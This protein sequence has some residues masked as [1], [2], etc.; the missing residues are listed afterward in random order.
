MNTRVARRSVRQVGGLCPGCAALYWRCQRAARARARIGDDE[1]RMMG[2]RSSHRGPKRVRGSKIHPEDRSGQGQVAGVL[3]ER[4]GL[5]GHST[6][7]TSNSWGQEP[8]RD[9]AERQSAE[10]FKDRMGTYCGYH[11]HGDSPLPIG[12]TMG[13]PAIDL[14]TSST[15]CRTGYLHEHLDAHPWGIAGKANPRRPVLAADKPTTAPAGL[16][17]EWVEYTICFGRLPGRPQL[18][19]SGRVVPRLQGGG[20]GLGSEFG[21][22][23]A[24]WAAR[25]G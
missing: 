8:G 22:R 13:V 5:P 24:G 20:D 14:T 17:M 16:P 11:G 19:A 12:K 6:A 21:P 10:E 2:A 7:K 23:G 15:R 18:L 3:A 25:T 4:T 1:G 9:G